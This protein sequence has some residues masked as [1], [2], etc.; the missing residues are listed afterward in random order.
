MVKMT[1]LLS[2]LKELEEKG[3][4]E[5]VFYEAAAAKHGLAYEFAKSSSGYGRFYFDPK[6]KHLIRAEFSP[7][8]IRFRNLPL[9]IATA[10]RENCAP[11]KA[12][13]ISLEMIR[14]RDFL[15]GRGYHMELSPTDSG[16]CTYRDK[17][18][19]VKTVKQLEKV[20]QDI[21]DL[22]RLLENENTRQA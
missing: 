21:S 1:Q 3:V 16:F 17:Y 18:L 20:L 6:D 4:S 19:K 14:A 15:I 13:E 8:R 9:F 7:P 12:M 10:I 2:K 5:D 22:D 11:E